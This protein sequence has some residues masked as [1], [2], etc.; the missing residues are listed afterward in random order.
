MGFEVGEPARGKVQAQTIDRVGGSLTGRWTT[1]EQARGSVRD[2]VRFYIL[3]QV[4]SRVWWTA[5]NRV[6][7]EVWRI[8][9]HEV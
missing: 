7:S 2:H 9:R 1:Q 6:R 4:S 3:V 8:L 5:A